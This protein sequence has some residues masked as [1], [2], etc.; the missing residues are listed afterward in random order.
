M[1]KILGVAK[2]MRKVTG[3]A[4]ELL[5]W[6]IIKTA[7]VTITRTDLLTCKL[8]KGMVVIVAVFV[9]RGKERERDVILL[10]PIRTEF[11]IIFKLGKEPI[12]PN[13]SCKK[14]LIFLH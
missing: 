10:M 12:D 5:T 6:I 7:F 13:Y 4:R 2:S 9:A 3:P 14:G 8:K 1:P 11:A